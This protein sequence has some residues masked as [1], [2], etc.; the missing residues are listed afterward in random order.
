MLKIHILDTFFCVS[1]KNGRVSMALGSNI[2][3][4]SCTCQSFNKIVLGNFQHPSVNLG[5][6]FAIDVEDDSEELIMDK[7]DTIMCSGSQGGR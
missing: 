5:N 2:Q 3:Q 4:L 7:R 1:Y 6:N